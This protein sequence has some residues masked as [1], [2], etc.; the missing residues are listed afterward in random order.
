[1]ETIHCFEKAGLGKAPFRYVGVQ[2]QDMRYGERV[3]NVGGVECTTHAGGTCE[4]CGH[5]IV[6]M[7]VI[8][9]ADGNRFHVGCDCL[10][11][12]GEKGLKRQADRDIREAARKRLAASNEERVANAIKRLPQVADILA[13][14]PHPNEYH[15]SQG[16]TLLDWCNWVIQNTNGLPAAKVIERT[17]R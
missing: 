13:G 12:V 14:K 17:E 7:F 3:V 4:Y 15:A 8:E 16:K 1:M 6:N 5:Y 9:S 10:A 11:K 2:F